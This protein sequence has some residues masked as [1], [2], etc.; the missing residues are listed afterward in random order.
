MYGPVNACLV[1][2]TSY[3]DGL[4]LSIGPATSFG[5]GALPGS[6]SACANVAPKS[7]VRWKTIV[8]LSGVS[9][10]E[11]GPPLDLSAPTIG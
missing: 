6:V 9:M 11:I 7:L 10:P 3:F 4:D 2:S 1:T 5:T 8:V